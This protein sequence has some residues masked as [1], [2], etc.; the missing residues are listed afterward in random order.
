[1]IGAPNWPSSIRLCEALKK[2]SS[3]TCAPVEQ[4][5]HHADVVIVGAFGLGRVVGMVGRR[6]GVV[7]QRDIRGSP[8]VR[9]AA[10]RNSAH[11]P[12]WTVV[13]VGRRPHHIDA[14][15]ELVFGIEGAVLV[16]A[17]AVIQRQAAERSSIR[18]GHRGRKLQACLVPLS[19]NGRAACPRSGRSGWDRC[20]ADWDWGCQ[21]RRTSVG[22]T[23]DEVRLTDIVGLIEH[24]EAHR[25]VAAQMPGAFRLHAIGDVA[26]VGGLRDAVVENVAD[27]GARREEQAGIAPEHRNLDVQIPVR[28]QIAEDAVM[29]DLALALVQVLAT[30]TPSGRWPA[31]RNRRCRDPAVPARQCRRGPMG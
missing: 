20:R 7:E 12:A 23:S 27:I 8:P 14:G 2:L 25:M 29:G 3:P 16:V 28:A 10:A 24:A 21:G 22:S 1:M 13:R 19:A 11:K 5:L 18:P 17:H 4:L 26:L 6:G 30:G 9:S 31:A 15:A